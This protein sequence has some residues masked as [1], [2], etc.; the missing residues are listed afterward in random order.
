MQIQEQQR[1]RPQELSEIYAALEYLQDTLPEY[2]RM[3][4]L[5]VA[6][7]KFVKEC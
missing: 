5:R 7:T 1:S 6:C 2:R 4:V 3:M